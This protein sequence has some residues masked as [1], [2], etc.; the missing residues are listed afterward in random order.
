M[1]GVINGLK[2]ALPGAGTNPRNPEKITIKAEKG[3]DLAKVSFTHLL[4]PA[5]LKIHRK[6]EWD[7][8]S[9]S[10]PDGAAGAPYYVFK[11]G[12]D[13]LSF[14][15]NFD[16]SEEKKTDLRPEVEKL[17]DL[18]YPYI[19]IKDQ[20]AK[21]GQVVAV[22]WKSF[23][24]TGVVE[25]V[26]ITVTLFDHEGAWKRASVAISMTGYAFDGKATK[27]ADFFEKPRDKTPSKK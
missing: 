6:V 14:T 15:L 8:V 5:D 12:T 17:Y 22:E 24:F 2:E 1:L 25:S 16:A 26:D 13:T 21:R 3:T 27:V 18:T 20:D 11:K 4:N 23:H 7:P 19:K 10:A 9:G